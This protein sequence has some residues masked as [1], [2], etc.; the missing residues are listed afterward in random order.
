MVV[1][2]SAVVTGPI[3]LCWVELLAVSFCFFASFLW[4][5]G[6]TQTGNNMK[7]ILEALDGEQKENIDDHRS[8]Q[9]VYEQGDLSQGGAMG[10]GTA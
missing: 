9:S 7:S 6:H 3:S 5:S 4:R 8:T 2:L 1:L 10:T